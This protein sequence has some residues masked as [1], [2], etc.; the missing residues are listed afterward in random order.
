AD[1]V[2]TCVQGILVLVAVYVI[3]SIGCAQMF[4]TEIAARIAQFGFGTAG[5]AFL[6]GTIA[7][8]VVSLRRS[9]ITL[10]TAYG[11]LGAWLLLF[12]WAL[13]SQER[14]PLPNL[15]SVIFVVGLT[16]LVVA[17]FAAMPLAMAS[18]RAR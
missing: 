18:N 14:D 11:A 3:V 7:V 1:R 15:G 5:V 2:T 17:P 10:R 9:C 16:A 6:L 4:S 12:A 13:V 8:F